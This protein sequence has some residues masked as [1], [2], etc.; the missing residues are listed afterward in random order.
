MGQDVDSAWELSQTLAE[1]VEA[2]RLFLAQL[3]FPIP[4]LPISLWDAEDDLRKWV[5]STPR[6]TDAEKQRILGGVRK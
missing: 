3:T 1:P 6:L 5:R 4:K 2:R